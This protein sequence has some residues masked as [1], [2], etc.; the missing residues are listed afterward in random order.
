MNE[1]PAPIAVFVY[2]RARHTARLLQSLTQNAEA[3]S[4]P[5][6]VFCDGPRS[7]ADVQQVHEARRVARHLAPRHSVFVESD[8]N[9]GLAN[10]IIAGVTRLTK[11]HGRVIV[12]EDD[13]V[14]SRYALRYMNDA[15]RRYAD[16]ERVMHISAYMFPVRA[17]LSEA[18]FYR[19]A[20]CWGW[21]TWQRAWAHFEPDGRRIRQFVEQRDAQYD[22]DVRGSIG[23]LNMLDQQ[24]TGKVDSWAIRWYGSM[25]M[26]QGLA[27]HPGQSLVE[28]RGF[29]GTGAHCSPTTAFDVR[30][31]DRPVTQFPTRVEESQEALVAMIAYR[32]QMPRLIDRVRRKLWQVM[33]P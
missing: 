33:R 23:F 31:A 25:Y 5:V 16:V 11:E 22:F 10:S 12:L 13:L 1:R 32:R 30:I 3:D 19:E 9:V 18:F 7:D 17:R 26:A 27:L 29:D 21:A 2:K 6:Y 15:L 8:V 24:I 20:T 14:L 4:S 28:N